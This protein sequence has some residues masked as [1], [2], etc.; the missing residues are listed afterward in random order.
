MID[1][2]AALA[3]TLRPDHAERL[4]GALVRARLRAAP[5][6]DRT[7]V[8]DALMLAASCAHDAAEDGDD[9]AWESAQRIAATVAAGM[10]GG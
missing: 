9:G 3:L 4:A 2:L 10:A 1:A 6:I 5:G 8:G 7:L